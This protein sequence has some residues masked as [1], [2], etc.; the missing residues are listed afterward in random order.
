M[1]VREGRSVRTSF[2]M[3]VLICSWRSRLI[4]R[5][6]NTMVRCASIESWSRWKRAG[7]AGRFWPGPVAGGA[8]G[9]AGAGLGGRRGPGPGRVDHRPGRDEHHRALG[10]GHN[11]A[12]T[13]ET[14]GFHPLLAYSGRPAVSGGEA[15]AGCC[16]PPEQV[17][18]R[19][20]DPDSPRL[21]VRT[22]AA[23]ATHTTSPPRCGNGAASSPSGSASTRRCKRRCCPCP[24]PVGQLSTTSMARPATERGSPRSP[25]EG[26]C[27]AGRNDPG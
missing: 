5:A 23:G 16:G 14:F 19:S 24:R 8:R 7:R 11:A 26:T 21:L 13:W 27:R 20:D 4:A 25:A 2:A 15:L 9:C 3:D 22:D 18:P 6:A 17:R 1:T 10:E 12:K